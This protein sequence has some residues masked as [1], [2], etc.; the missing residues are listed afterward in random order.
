MPQQIPTAFEH[1]YLK[2]VRNCFQT[3]AFTIIKKRKC[4]QHRWKIIEQSSTFLRKP[5]P[6]STKNLFRI[7]K[8]ASLDR[9][10]RQ[11]APRSA[12]GC[13]RSLG[14]LLSILDR[15]FVMSCLGGNG[16]HHF[17]CT[18]NIFGL[19]FFLTYFDLRQQRL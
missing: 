19:Q 12:P 14:V 10:R 15:C 7:K 5:F 11:F 3:I 4:V 17:K 1:R 18:K 8:N 6:K 9:F 16:G 13:H 2:Y